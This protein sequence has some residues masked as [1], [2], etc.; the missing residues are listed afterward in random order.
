M[1]F[2]LVMGIVPSGSRGLFEPCDCDNIGS[3]IDDS[4]PNRPM[5]PLEPNS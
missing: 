5:G 1:W 2:M 3:M 4:T